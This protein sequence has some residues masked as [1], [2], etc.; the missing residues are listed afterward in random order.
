MKLLL[1]D[2]ES[3]V[4]ERIRL[5]INWQEIGID[6]L[7][8]C[9]DG[10]R[11]LSVIRTFKPDILVTDI[12]MPGLD[13]IKLAEEYLYHNP[14]AKVI[15][16]SGY[17]DVP[18]LR[19][20]IRLRAV[21]YVEKPIDIGELSADIRT[22]VEEISNRY[23]VSLD[24]EE[25]RA[26]SLFAQ[27]TSIAKSLINEENRPEAVQALKDYFKGKTFCLFASGIT[28]LF[29]S[30]KGGLGSTE[31]LFSAL[32]PAF[33]N[34]GIGLCFF[35]DEN[36]L[37]FHILCT[38][39]S[40]KKAPVLTP[41]FEQVTE[42][43]AQQQV[44]C[45][46]VIGRFIRD[47][48]QLYKS[49][50]SAIQSLPRYY[51][52][53]PGCLIL[54]QEEKPRSLDLNEIPLSAYSHAL[55]K[56]N[57][58]MIVSMLNNLAAQLKM[59]DGTLP[60]DVLRFY[61]SIIMRMYRDAEKENILLFDPPMDEYRMLDRLRSCHF[62]D[63]LHEYTLGVIRD[64]YEKVNNHYTDNPVVNKIIGYVQQ[65]YANQELSIG[66]ISEHMNLSSS[67]LAHLFRNVTGCTLGDY[68]TRVRIDKAQEI[69]DSGE[70]R[71]KDVA[72][73]VGYRNGNYFSYAF[74]KHK[75]FAPSE[76]AED[77]K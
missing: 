29:P 3:F 50:Q 71:V 39:E 21:S 44:T 65:N 62:L 30:E 74:K 58:E 2:D 64:Y 6:Q 12:R 4:R 76:R 36:R 67:Y 26:K 34:A 70:Y 68:L 54:S 23:Q 35:Q 63:E 18:Y 5:Q 77:P 69:M 24:R 1:V 28:Q 17:S 27:Q 15:F 47:A 59:N 14:E 38:D 41:L 31:E 55:Q 8:V 57:S 75:G 66:L 13:G 52:R 32:M 25:L 60:S 20:A 40:Q 43:L 42:Y 9:D 10:E 72:R 7:E 73:M 48:S 33:E 11:A 19:S 16:I 53:E 51:Y 49:Y 56:E 22:A 37:V 45:C 46:H 61:Y